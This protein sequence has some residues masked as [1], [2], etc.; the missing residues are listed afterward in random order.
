[1]R[2]LLPPRLVSAARVLTRPAFG[3]Y[4]CVVVAAIGCMTESGPDAAV[5]A[6]QAATSRAAT[7]ASLG[8]VAADATAAGVTLPSSAAE[9]VD[10]TP[11]GSSVGVR[12]SLVGASAT[13]ATASG[14]V[15]VHR[16]ALAGADVA[17]VPLHDGV[18]DVV[19]F[20]RAPAREE[21]VYELDV[22]RAAGLRLVAGALE[23]L[24]ARGAP[25][26]RVERP[27]LVDASGAHRWL[28]T[29]VEGCAVDTDPRAPWDRAVTPP[30]AS[31][32]RLVV[33]WKGASYP[34][35]V[36]PTWRLSTS[37]SPRFDF[38]TF[39]YSNGRIIACGG[40]LSVPGLGGNGPVDSC[41]LFD[42]ATLTW[43][44]GPTLPAGREEGAVAALPSGRAIFLGGSTGGSR[45]ELITSAGA[46]TRSEDFYNPGG[47]A[48]A[49][50]LA[51]GKVL[52]TGGN[53]ANARLY[54]EGTDTYANAGAAGV[55]N[56][57]RAF[58]TSTRLGS[59][60]VLVAGGGGASAEI[61]DPATNTF[62]LVPGGM[63]ASRQGHVAALL[64]DG[65][66][67]VAFG[68][69]AT[70]EIYDPVTNAFTATGAGA[71][72]RSRAS[73][74]MLD[75]GDIMVLGGE[76]PGPIG[77]IEIFDAVTKTFSP[78]P[79]LS[80]AR[81]RLGAAKISPTAGA[82]GEVAAFGGRGTTGYSLGSTE[83]WG[84]GQA[85]SACTTGDDC[86]S[87]DCQEGI[88]CAAS[89]SGSC[90]TCVAATG[91]CVV[92]TKADDPSTCTGANT[93]DAAGS[94]K[95]KNGQTCAAA[96]D[97]ASGFC[98]D[99]A[100]CDRACNGQCEACNV[101]GVVG[102][103]API[104]GAPHG[105][106]P[107]C[108]ATGSTCGG[109]CNGAD[110][111][112]C[113][114]PGSVTTCGTA[115]AGDK[116]TL[117]TCDGRGGC[118]TDVARSCAGNFV[119]ADEKVCKVA[120]AT[121]ADCATGYQCIG[122]RCLPIALCE[123][124]FVTKGEQRID[125]FPYTCEQTGN[126]KTTCASVSDCIAPTVCSLDGQCVD[127]PAPPDTGCTV[128]PT[129]GANAGGGN[130]RGIGV[131]LLAVAVAFAARS[132]RSRSRRDGEEV[133]R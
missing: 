85:G 20:D 46:V 4:A 18:E 113:A 69:S 53:S 16:G 110:G 61:Y 9:P 70:A 121:N 32:C 54:D 59:G 52:V 38:Q 75:S 94:C 11:R 5:R 3:G 105:G 15:R 6:E 8:I 43:A 104:A 1:M 86:R 107:A 99:G 27:W 22:S 82:K 103:C 102:S 51:N 120:C 79:T 66:V 68:G 35:I 26:V 118:A 62:T 40:R 88:C 84:P 133:A 81:T 128:A 31:T 114:Y 71:A 96:G 76:A 117:S 72:D 28:D 122:A 93:C 89:C 14:L 100:C 44:G 106:R 42:A 119:C 49:V 126:C 78:Q 23:L 19:F 63:T 65:K 116:L 56:T 2:R 127:P 39:A 83:I 48:S 87:G 45:A 30:G 125:C 97:C 37:F 131:V 10:L 55:M 132:R 13:E 124:R 80:F 130:E 112:T 98:V 108:N 36:D 109:T 123:E 77:T 50:L 91:A 24:D 74:V 73:A 92:V 111:A 21:L 47:G 29:R 60:K 34:A 115:C 101:P 7:I 95:K 12:F 33:S 67:L 90:K 58:H 25:R 129:P 17:H 57:A 41:S 64:P